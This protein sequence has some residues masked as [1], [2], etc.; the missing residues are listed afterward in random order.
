MDY[1]GT[2]LAPQG[3]NGWDISEWLALALMLAPLVIV[4]IDAAGI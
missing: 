1:I 2:G 3:G 4:A